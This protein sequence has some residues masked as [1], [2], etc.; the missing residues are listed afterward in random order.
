MNKIKKDII[1]QSSVIPQT[2]W[3]ASC[4]ENKKHFYSVSRKK[5]YVAE[6]LVC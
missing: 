6:N 2:S 5:I 1:L 3:E 4:Y